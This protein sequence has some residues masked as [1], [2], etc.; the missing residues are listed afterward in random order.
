M[1][2]FMCYSL[3]LAISCIF[4]LDEIEMSVCPYSPVP[5][6]SGFW[7]HSYFFEWWT[8]SYELNHQCYRQC[9]IIIVVWWSKKLLWHDHSR[10]LYVALYYSLLF[11]GDSMII[12]MKINY[13]VIIRMISSSCG[14]QTLDSYCAN[15]MERSQYAKTNKILIFENWFE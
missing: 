5:T 12:H 3:L 8:H 13:W 2:V 11:E 4:L 6:E 7:T 9:C 1:H 14:Q 15:E 10:L